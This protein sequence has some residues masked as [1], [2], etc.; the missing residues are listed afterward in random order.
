MILYPNLYLGNILDIEEEIINK[1]QIKGLLIDVDNTIMKYDK[2][3]LEGI[4]EW[5]QKMKDLNVKLCIL[6]NTNNKKKVERVSKLLDIP[7]IYL[8]NKPFKKGFKK[9]KM[10]LGIEEKN[11][12]VVGDQIFTD[13]LGANRM[14]MISILTVPLEKRDILITKVKRPIENYIIKMYKKKGSR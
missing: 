1:N 4:E 13:I 5:T 2:S 11:I 14:K 3:L 9:G 12:A 8:A 10:L 7:F 6:S